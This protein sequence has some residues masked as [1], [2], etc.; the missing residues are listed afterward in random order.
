MEQLPFRSLMQSAALLHS[1]GN[2]TL[3]I[4]SCRLFSLLQALIPGIDMHYPLFTMQQL[5]SYTHVM[6]VGGRGGHPMD[7][8]GVFVHADMHLCLPAAA[9]FPRANAPL[10]PEKSFLPDGAAPESDGTPG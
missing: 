8:P 2:A 7:Q 3:H 6:D 9:G 10:L 4:L 1:H 5:C